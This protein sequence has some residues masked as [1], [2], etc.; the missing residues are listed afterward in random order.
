MKALKYIVPL[1]AVLSAGIFAF[2]E[3]KASKGNLTDIPDYLLILGCRVKGY[4]AEDILRSRIEAAGKYLLQ[5]ET[6]KAICCGGIVH[7]DQFRSEADAIKEGLLGMGIDESRIILEDKSTTTE[8]NFINAKGIIEALEGE[9]AV[10][11]AFLTSE[12]HLMRASYIAKSVGVPCKC[13]PAKTP[14]N[15]RYGAYLR[16]LLVYPVAIV[17]GNR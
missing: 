13:T 7:P 9:K 2:K 14:L 15:K 16:E 11:I 1:A 6:V 5:N 3:A 8:E 17:R 10:T 12:F 4:E